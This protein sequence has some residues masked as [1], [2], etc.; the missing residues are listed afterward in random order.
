MKLPK[1]LQ[2][3]QPLVYA[4]LTRVGSACDGGYLIPGRPLA[5]I[6]GLISFGVSVDWN[7]EKSI[8]SMH[9]E[10]PIHCYDHTVDTRLFAKHFAAGVLNVLRGRERLGGP[11]ARLSVWRDYPRFFQGATRHYAQR[12]F[13]RRESPMDATIDMI[14]ERVEAS[15]HLLLKMDIEGGEY[16]VIPEI[17]KRADRV[18]ILIVEFHDT[19]PL[20]AVFIAQL[21]L[22]LE[23]FNVAHVHGNNYCGRAEDGL[24]DALEVTF[25]NRR[26]GAGSEKRANLPLQGLDSPCNPAIPELEL[27]F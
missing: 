1:E 9:S 22:L 19:D 11:L 24:P 12:V 7:F 5:G 20:R 4:D 10:I 18:D 6:D 15:R 27:A 26:F 13:N 16:R 17:V 21:G 23:H 25:V 8:R 2:I 3:L 14:F